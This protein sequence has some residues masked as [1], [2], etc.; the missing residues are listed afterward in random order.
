MASWQAPSRLVGKVPN[1]LY[2]LTFSKPHFRSDLSGINV[3][4]S[5]NN[6]DGIVQEFFPRT[7]DDNA[8]STHCSF[9]H[10]DIGPITSILIA[11]QSSPWEGL[12]WVELDDQVYR[13]RFAH[14]KNSN[15]PL[16][17]PEVIP[18]YDAEKH[19]ASMDAYA[20]LKRDILTCTLWLTLLGNLGFASFSYDLTHVVNFDIGCVLGLLYQK[21][22]HSRVDSVGP[23]TRTNV[24]SIVGL[25]GVLFVV[26]VVYVRFVTGAAAG[27]HD[28]WSV[29]EVICG[30]MMNKLAVNIVSVWRC[31]E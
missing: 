13:V 3:C 23:G 14:D 6:G 1:K 21:M 8:Y 11:P 10:S 12:E 29:V 27:T 2:K 18:S 22:L 5:N 20:A 9:D 15:G 28:D 19:K 30:F 17:L 31:L 7:S 25:L 16:Y 24:P 26:S 4:M